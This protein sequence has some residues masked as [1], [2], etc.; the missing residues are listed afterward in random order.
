MQTSQRSVCDFLQAFA[1][2]PNYYPEGYTPTAGKDT[3][4]AQG[5]AWDAAELGIAFATMRRD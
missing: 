5:V 3:K 4:N 2:V 1:P